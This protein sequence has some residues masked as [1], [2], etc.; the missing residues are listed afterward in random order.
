MIP[1]QNQPNR[2]N[3]RPGEQEAEQVSEPE[4][5]NSSDFLEEEWS[6]ERELNHYFSPEREEL[7]PL[8][9]QT[10]L[11]E[12]GDWMVPAKLEAR[13]TERVFQALQLP[14]QPA[15][16]QQTR[17]RLARQLAYLPR[18]LGISSAFLTGM[19]ALL[20]IITPL[21]QQ[22]SQLLSQTGFPG[23][24]SAALSSL[25]LT[26]YL[27]PRQTQAAIN[28]PVYWLGKNPIN[29][30]FESLL[31]HMNQSWSDGPVVE[32]QYGHTDARIG[33]GRLTIREFR[34]A[35]GHTA[36]EVVDP[37]AWE[38]A[39]VGD[40]P[41]IIVIGQWTHQNGELL[42]DADS[43]VQLFYQEN[44]IVF[45]LTAD[46]RDEATMQGLVSLTSLF[47]E[48]YLGAPNPH[49]PELSQPP[50]AIQA[51]PLL[52]AAVGKQIDQIPVGISTTTDAIVYLALGQPPNDSRVTANNLPSA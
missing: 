50:R 2:S 19:M 43:Q 33:Y 44:G 9:I 23:Y 30:N 22:V 18:T 31:L 25:A 35:G 32:V 36:L 1:P 10:M 51:E 39:Q 20:M 14:S 46:Q 11:S 47:R 13:L 3:P 49:L 38:Q 27:S 40:Q 17:P 7:P 29:Y 45:W 37:Y 8:Y 21:A 28:F 34:P 41:G 16:P 52:P 42:W 26:H 12:Q 15:Q 48:L 6:L 5:R 24:G 4:T